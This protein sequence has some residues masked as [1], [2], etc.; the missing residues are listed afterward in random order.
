MT[1]IIIREFSGH[2]LEWG[3]RFPSGLYGDNLAQQFE[4]MPGCFDK[5]LASGR[6]VIFSVDLDR[7]ARASTSDGTLRIEADDIGML[8]TV[9]LLD[10][11]AN[12]E[13]SRLIGNGRVKG[14]SFT[15]RPQFG[16]FRTRPVDGVSLTEHFNCGLSEV[17]VVIRKR[18]RATSRRTP[19]FISNE[20]ILTNV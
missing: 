1:Q 4:F 18:P 17:C 12:R 2:F 8:A 7:T 10:T 20:R 13:L 6:E 5:S 3:T 14:W 9:Q 11:P 16:G 19:I 15:A